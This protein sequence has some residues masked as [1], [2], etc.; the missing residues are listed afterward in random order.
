[1]NSS[2]PTWRSPRQRSLLSKE[3][4]VIIL[5]YYH[6]HHHHLLEHVVVWGGLCSLSPLK[7]RRTW[8]GN[9]M[10]EKEIGQRMR[11]GEMDKGQD[12]AGR[13]MEKKWGRQPSL[14]WRR[15]RSKMIT[16]MIDINSECS[17]AVL[18]REVGSSQWLSRIRCVTLM[19][20]T[21]LV[22]NN[23]NNEL[24][25]TLTYVHVLGAQRSVCIYA[26]ALIMHNKELIT[27]SKSALYECC[28]SLS[29]Q[30]VSSIAQIIKSCVC[31]WVSES[32]SESVI[33][34]ILGPLHISGTVKARN[35]KFGTQIGH[36]G[37]KRNNVKLGQK[38]PEGVTW[39]TFRILGP[40]SYLGNGWS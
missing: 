32:V 34:W 7:R 17:V 10:K 31:Q 19:D 8:E 9:A 4:W 3:P 35:F 25:M 30:C 27:F 38:G 21:Q 1:M 29:A 20:K 39:P 33:Q 36:G 28:C 26:H 22:N 16:I 18:C 6:H 14:W 13:G 15:G 37:P 5:M 24:L 23:N 40:P 12:R 11:A 2:P